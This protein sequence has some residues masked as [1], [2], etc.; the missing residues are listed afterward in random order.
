M[1]RV[2]LLCRN[3]RLGI[4]GRKG[5]HYFLIMNYDC[6]VFFGNLSRSDIKDKHSLKKTLK[7]NAVALSCNIFC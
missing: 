6:N 1:S 5:T 7:F 2:N 4:Y 3:E